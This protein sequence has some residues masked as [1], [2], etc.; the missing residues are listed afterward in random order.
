MANDK[1]YYV[2]LKPSAG[3]KLIKVTGIETYARTDFTVPGEVYRDEFSFTPGTMTHEAVAAPTSIPVAGVD[4]DAVT[5]STT[6]SGTIKTI[7]PDSVMHVAP[8]QGTYERQAHVFSD[9]TPTVLGFFWDEFVIGVT[10]DPT[11]V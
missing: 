8:R 7:A 9:N 1:T 4:G 6:F 3:G 2:K 5:F 11:Q 10:D